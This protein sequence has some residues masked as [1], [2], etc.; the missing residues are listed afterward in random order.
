MVG[1]I[2]RS[3]VLASIGSILDY[4]VHVDDAETDPAYDQVPLRAILVRKG[5]V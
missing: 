1:A 5:E 4:S 2:Q 3:G